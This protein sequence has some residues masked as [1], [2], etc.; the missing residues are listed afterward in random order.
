MLTRE[1]IEEIQAESREKGVPIKRLLLEKGVPEHQYFWWKRKPPTNVDAGC[2]TRGDERVGD[3]CAH[4]RG[5]AP[6]E[7]IVLA[8]LLS[9]RAQ[10]WAFPWPNQALRP[11]RAQNRP[12]LWPKLRSV[13][14][15]VL[16]AI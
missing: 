13:K 10:N 15:L 2:L 4:S 8:P 16:K 1:Q 5:M 9:S 14:Y 11:A 3:G 12:I 7:E 6:R